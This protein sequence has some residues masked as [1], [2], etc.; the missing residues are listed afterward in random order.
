[1][2]ERK[3]VGS[4][5]GPKQRIIDMLEFAAEKKTYPICEVYDYEDFPK[6]WDRLRYER[7]RFRCVVKFNHN[8]N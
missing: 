5:V 2:T 6:A 8:L 4:L 7:P 1:M 3:F